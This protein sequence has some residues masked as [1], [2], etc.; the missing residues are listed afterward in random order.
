MIYHKSVKTKFK[1]I[2]AR[3]VLVLLMCMFCFSC[4]VGC[5]IFD[6]LKSSPNYG[7]NNEVGSSDVPPTH[8]DHLPPP[9]DGDDDEDQD[10]DN[11]TEE[12]KDEA[13]DGVSVDY[14][15]VLR[16]P[17]SYDFINNVTDKEGDTEGNRDY[18]YNFSEDI[19]WWLF[20]TYG[21]FNTD[22]KNFSDTALNNFDLFYQITQN[23][24]MDQLSADFQLNKDN[25]LYWYDAIRYRIS[26]VQPV[27]QDATDETKTTEDAVQAAVDTDG[28]PI[29]KSYKVGADTNKGWQWGLK[30]DANEYLAYVY[31]HN[32][33]KSVNLNRITNSFDQDIYNYDRFKSYYSGISLLGEPELNTTAFSNA[34]INE[35]YKTALEYAIYNIVLGIEPH[36][37]TISYNSSTGMPSISVEGY[38]P[39][40][41]ADAKTSAQ[42]A[43]ADIKAT[44]NRLGS[45][46]GLTQ[47]NKTQITKYVLENVI[48]E[49]LT[50]TN[51]SYVVKNGDN[52]AFATVDYC[53][54]DVVT[55]IVDYCGNL[56]TIGVASG[57]ET[58]DKTYIKDSFIASEI[59]DYPLLKFFSNNG[60]EDAFKGQKPYEYQS[61]VIM[62]SRETTITDLW[63]DFKYDAG[64]DG[65]DIF[66][67]TKFLDITV[68]VRWN[69]GDGSP[70][71]VTSQTIRVIDGPADVGDTSTLEFE[72]EPERK[73]Y[74]FGEPL[75]I[76]KFNTP[77][78]LKTT[79]ETLLP[80]TTERGIIV[81]GFT[82]ARRYYKVLE[83]A[84]Y[85]GY[86][87]LDESKIDC[88][89]LEIA[90]SVAKRPGDT[91]T[92]YAFYTSIHQIWEDEEEDTSWMH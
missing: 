1:T 46:V 36:N 11:M 15:K 65:D 78:A 91:T 70:I 67:P 89:Y 64:N 63:L 9:S 51:S 57:E 55:A 25:Y 29:I 81:T 24:K 92:N 32:E 39:T 50:G 40:T 44:F 19:L 14:V 5:S 27:Y 31:G 53:Y 20:R 54:E 66:D 22:Y 12:E 79:A 58:D 80:G 77:D 41:G 73:Q 35:D 72:F 87:V 52:G 34:F 62:P 8:P 76:G 71:H 60:Y 88:S 75:T 84:T 13:T 23:E 33:T 10:P 83:S 69:K 38:A 61:A 37:I 48:G 56:T 6:G 17:L 16:K 86:G 7:N 45:Y 21:N 49:D 43:L 3:C 30:Y 90:Y 18:Y 59:V 68:S 4:T 26:D 74:L 82:D 28:N 47:K 42:V 85:G 2:F